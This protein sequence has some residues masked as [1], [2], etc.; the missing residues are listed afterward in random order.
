VIAT[1]L[2]A[3]L[4]VP[5]PGP[6]KATPAPQASPAGAK[7][8]AQEPCLSASP[9]SRIPSGHPTAFQSPAEPFSFSP[10]PDAPPTSKQREAVYE[11]LLQAF[12]AALI[13][14]R[15]GSP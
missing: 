4:P 12:L 8:D 15:K 10:L 1:E 3:Q 11:P 14:T 7:S 5:A 9:P 2:P 13:S 6:A